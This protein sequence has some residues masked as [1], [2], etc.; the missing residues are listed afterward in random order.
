MPTL[1]LNAPAATAQQVL[2][3]LADAGDVIRSSGMLP[4]FVQ[5]GHLLVAEHHAGKRTLAADSWHWRAAR[6]FDE[7]QL[8][9]MH[10][11]FGNQVPPPGSGL[12]IV[13]SKGHASLLD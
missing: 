13:Q 7:A 4:D 1:D 12:L 3:G 10:A 6:I 11:C 9:A 8:A 5:A 2:R